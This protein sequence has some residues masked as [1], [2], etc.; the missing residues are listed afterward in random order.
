MFQSLLLSQ[1]KSELEFKKKEKKDW[2]VYKLRRRRYLAGSEDICGGM[3]IGQAS[4]HKIQEAKKIIDC[5]SRDEHERRA[6]RYTCL[7]QVLLI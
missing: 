3:A 5:T 6:C 2:A 4:L 7:C 1:L